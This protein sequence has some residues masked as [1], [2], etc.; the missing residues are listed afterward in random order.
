[1]RESKKPDLSAPRFRVNRTIIA[2]QCMYKLFK[3]KYPQY[4]HVPDTELRKILDTLHRNM[5]RHVLDNRDGVELFERLG[6]VFLGSCSS[7][8]KNNVNYS[9][10]TKLE[11]QVKHRNF[12]S[13]N[14]LAKIFYTNF[15]K[16]Q[17]TNREVWKFSA[18]R[19]FRRAVPE[20][21][22]EHW[23]RYL[24]VDSYMRVSRVFRLNKRKF[25]AMENEQGTPEGYNEF[26][27]D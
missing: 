24:Q 25:W 4:A 6:Y 27:L 2:N 5:Y 13:D 21:Y 18:I 11:K 20:V 22:R 12:E 19:E 17:F 15:G 7:P 10:S 23:K 16:Y 3:R 9:L 26:D 14:F 1:M 8:K